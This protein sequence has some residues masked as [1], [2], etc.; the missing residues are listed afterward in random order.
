LVGESKYG[1]RNRHRERTKVPLWLGEKGGKINQNSR[2]DACAPYGSAPPKPQK[3]NTPP[4]PTKKNNHQNKTKKKKN[5]PPTTHTQPTTKNKTPKKTKTKKS[6][7][8]GSSSFL[9][10]SGGF[11]VGE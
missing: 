11:S 10:K 2:W 6:V 8:K 7:P 4:T 1:L 3:H 5:P 9:Q